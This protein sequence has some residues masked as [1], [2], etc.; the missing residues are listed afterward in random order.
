[1][2]A[3]APSVSAPA[4]PVP[5]RPRGPGIWFK[6]GFLVVAAGAGVWY[7]AA[8]WDETGPALRQIGW[9]PALASVPLVV[10][11]GIA[12]M[13]AWRRLLAD[14]GHPLPVVPAARV[15]YTS[16]LGKYLPGS[17]WTF[18]AQVELAKQLKVP[19]AVSFAV[20]VLAVVLSLAVGLGMAVVLLPFGAGDALRRFWWLWLVLPVLVAAIH[21]AVTTW[22]INLLLR[23]FRRPPIAV[24]PTGRG[25]LA[26]TAWQVLSWCLMG[27][28]CFILVRAAGAEG[29]SVLPLA[30]GGFTLAYC[31]GLLFVPAP[32]G[33]G[34]RELA[35]G[36][37]LATAISPQAAAAVVLV[38]RLV[39]AAVDMGMAALSIHRHHEERT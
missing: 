1:M 10:G 19:R 11:A 28:H 37:A 29:W 17:V 38:S 8:N 21:P 13:L 2:T 35:L 22:G 39:L 20:S 9:G 4:P 31:A 7:I 27:L 16:Q 5:R 23:I 36:A 30:V 12:G 6:I 18:V 3:P 34:V 25:M 32:A 15:F 33:I 24:R 26:A 14:L